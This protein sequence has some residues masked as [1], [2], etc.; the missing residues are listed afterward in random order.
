MKY[1]VTGD[2]EKFMNIGWTNYVDV[3]YVLDYFYGAK[4]IQVDLETSGSSFKAASIHSMQLGDRDFQFII[5]AYTI[6]LKLFKELIESVVVIG[7]NLSFDLPFLYNIGIVPKECWDTYLA[8]Y[9][10]TMGLRLPPGSRSLGAIVKKYLDVDMDKSA[11]STIADSGLSSW[12]D[13]EY[14][15]EDVRYLHDVARMQYKEAQ[16]KK[17]IQ[18][19]RLEN[20]FV[21]VVSYIEFSGVKV[22]VLKW[23]SNVREVEYKE[24]KAWM[25]LTEFYAQAIGLDEAPVFPSLPVNWLSSKQVVEVMKHFGV[26]VVEDGKETV[27]AS[28]LMKELDKHPI[29][30]LYLKYRELN[31]EVTTYGREWLSNVLSD[32]KVHTKYKSMVDTGRT[33][34]GDTKFGPFPNMQNLPAD[35]RIR[36]CFIPSNKRN[37]FV[38]CDYSSQESVLLA[39]MSQESNLL[40]F[41]LNGEADLHSYAASKIWA[42]EIGSTPLDEVKSK[43]P[44]YRQRA[45]SANFAI[46]YGGSGYTIA[47]NL[48]IPPAQGEAVYDAYMKAFPGLAKFFE[49]QKR[50]VFEKGYILINEKTGRKRFGEGI[51]DVHSKYINIEWTRYKKDKEYKEECQKVMKQKGGIEREAL[52]TPIQGTAADMSKLAGVKFFN[53][54]VEKKM[55]G[56]ILIP[57]F[58][59]DE[60][61]VECS[62]GNAE[63]VATKLKECMEDAG[64]FFLSTLKINAE[65]VITE[66]WEH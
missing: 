39:D 1:V 25:E 44:E 53:W 28:V 17:L 15:G 20:E 65:P 3:Q 58:V 30:P 19:V 57:I 41:Y 7:Q 50:K 59:H 38:V 42:S 54:I 27:D 2:E 8:E 14:S 37:T 63:K 46:S 62:K 55:F 16:R 56:K 51:K 43:F 21:K 33:S 36:G 4:S 13:V 45:K 11:Q 52:N 9:V 23:M 10:L 66:Q 49:E 34:C 47:N 61:V 5:D 12:E 35:S 64:N 60:Y 22:D 26:N 6:D 29:V 24:Y 32:G 48:N 18:A 40:E 31:K